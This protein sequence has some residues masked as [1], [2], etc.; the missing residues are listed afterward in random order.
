MI[1]QLDNDND[2]DDY[3]SNYDDGD[4]NDDSDDE[5]DA[6]DGNDIDDDYDDDVVP[7][8]FD[9]AVIDSIPSFND[10]MVLTRSKLRERRCREHM[11]AIQL[12]CL[13]PSRLC[14]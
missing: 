6:V 14:S 9:N 13:Q 11:I 1:R 8:F 10:C 3:D 4:D 12:K 5:T 7:N 2:D